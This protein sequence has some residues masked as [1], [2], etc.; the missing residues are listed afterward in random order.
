MSEV[1]TEPAGEYDPCPL[2]K[3]YSHSIGCDN[4]AAAFNH[5]HTMIAHPVRGYPMGHA[6][7]EQTRDAAQVM[8]S[9]RTPKP[10]GEL[11][12]RVK[13]ALSEF[14]D[15]YMTSNTHHPGYVLIP[16]EQ[17]DR[18]CIAR[19]TI[20]AMPDRAAL[21]A[22]VAGLQAFKDYVHQRL[23]GAGILTHPDGEH[24]K[25]GC[26]VGDRLDI[27]LDAHTTLRTQLAASQADVARL[28]EV[29][30]SVELLAK[31][32]RNAEKMVGP[33]NP[34]ERRVWVKTRYADGRAILAAI[35]DTQP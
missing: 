10:A 33:E 30:A 6:F 16:A 34:T 26:R 31:N 19:A 24:S 3:Q 18:A 29:L 23:D 13:D 1:S 11:V 9:L 28:R 17:F 25:A 8:M 21:V 7:D 32:M 35:K 22:E 4:V 14:G 20:A 2:C 12:E 15:D 5:F 27:A